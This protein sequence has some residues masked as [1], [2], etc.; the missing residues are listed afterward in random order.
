MLISCLQCAGNNIQKSPFQWNVYNK[1]K[2]FG[3]TWR[4]DFQHVYIYCKS[5]VMKHF[6]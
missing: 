3:G 4:T 2:M 1:I 6:L 5:Y